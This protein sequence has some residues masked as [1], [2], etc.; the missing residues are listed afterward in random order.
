MRFSDITNEAPKNDPEE[1]KRRLDK[2]K[3]IN[4]KRDQEKAD[5]SQRAS[6][7]G[8]KG[9][10]AR[11]FNKDLKATGMDIR[12]DELAKRDQEVSA[13]DAGGQGEPEQ[14]TSPEQSAN[15][16]DTEK[17]LVAPFIKSQI[18]DRKRKRG[19]EGNQGVEEKD[20]L[21]YA[22]EKYPNVDPEELEAVWKKITGASGGLKTGNLMKAADSGSSF[23][24][25]G[26]NDQ[27]QQSQQSEKPFNFPTDEPKQSAPMKSSSPMGSRGKA[28]P[29]GK[30]MSRVKQMSLRDLKLFKKE[31]SNA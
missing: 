31:L 28:N 30:I 22:K 19:V 7:L 29:M 15:L 8:K 5:R 2:A 3:G 18:R 16:N 13:Q 27:P 6:D 11:S 24:S 9:A 17:Q 25:D 12:K 20:V 10:E 23:Q 21:D 4:D 26:D 1:L 14:S